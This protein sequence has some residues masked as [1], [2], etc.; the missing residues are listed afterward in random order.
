MRSKLYFPC[1]SS[2][3][4]SQ[5]DVIGKDSAFSVLDL[6]TDLLEYV[7]SYLKEFLDENFG[8]HIELQEFYLSFSLLVFGFFVC[9][10]S[11]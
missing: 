8:L 11:A 6:G 7:F 5:W 3:V 4:L 10:V 9:A 2:C 1:Y